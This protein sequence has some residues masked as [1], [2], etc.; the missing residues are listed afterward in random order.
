MMKNLNIH[1]KDRIMGDP[2][3]CF[4]KTTPI[5]DVKT[6]KL[7]SVELP[8]CWYNVRPNMNEFTYSIYDS[9]DVL[10]NTY[11]IQVMSGT[12]TALLLCSALQTAINNQVVGT[13]STVSHSDIT[14]KISVSLT[15]S[16][17]IEIH[18]TNLT[19]YILGFNDG[20]KGSTITGLRNYNFNHDLYV[21]LQFS[22]CQSAFV[23]HPMT[24]KIPITKNLGEIQNLQ[25][26]HWFEQVVNVENQ[27]NL[28]SIKIQ[29]YDQYDNLLDNNGC[30]FSFT[31]QLT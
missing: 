31:L 5:S 6:M 20:Q 16:Y 23:N 24:F 15:N 21:S 4:I 1:T 8:L 29:V 17:Q 13:T 2:F 18:E 11:T 3:N 12:Y 27:T 19:K 9:F 25:M 10:I 14:N 26:N 30:D 28:S 22:G 7:L